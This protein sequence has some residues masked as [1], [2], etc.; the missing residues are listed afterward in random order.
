MALEGQTPPGGGERAPLLDIKRKSCYI[1]L[2][3]KSDQHHGSNSLPD[4]S[5]P[6][7]TREKIGE[8]SGSVKSE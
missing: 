7:S 8:G 5:V 2:N 3:S 6:V 4:P 1:I